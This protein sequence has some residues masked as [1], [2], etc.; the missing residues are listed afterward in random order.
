MGFSPLDG[1]KLLTGLKEHE[2][3]PQKTFLSLN[4]WAS[5]VLNEIIA[6]TSLQ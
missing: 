2:T 5:Y 4:A 6:V 3:S 1:S